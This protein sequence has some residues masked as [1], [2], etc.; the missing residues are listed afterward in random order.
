MNDLWFRLLASALTAVV[1]LVTYKAG[2]HLYHRWY[3]RRLRRMAERHAGEYGVKQV[4]L[5][6]SVSDD[7]RES[8]RGDLKARGLLGAGADIPIL[9]VHQ[10][11]GFGP[12]EGQWFAYLERVKAEIRTVRGEGFVR[13]HVY[14]RLPVA[15]AVMVGATLTNGPA[16]VVYHFHNGRYD[17]VGQVTFETTKL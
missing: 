11:E 16:A 2:E 1:S 12:M 3:N 17:P 5:A 14:T 10:P 13:V 6:L 4:A 15:L 7:I 9:A 8:V